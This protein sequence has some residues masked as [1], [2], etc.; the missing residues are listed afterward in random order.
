MKKIKDF[1]GIKS[2]SAEV[3]KAG[4]IMVELLEEFWRGYEIGMAKHFNCRCAIE[5]NVAPPVKYWD[6]K[7]M[8]VYPD[9]PAER[10]QMRKWLSQVPHGGVVGDTGVLIVYN[11]KYPELSE[12]VVDRV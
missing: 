1:F 2:P 6:V 9:E 8:P 5:L 7:A 12:L 4:E 10:Y 11:E 3:V